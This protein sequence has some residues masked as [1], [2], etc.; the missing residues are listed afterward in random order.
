V[1][2]RP[3]VL[4][5]LFLVACRTEDT[6]VTPDPHLERMLVQEKRLAYQADPLPRGMAMQNPPDGTLPVDTPVGDPLVSEGVA[7]GQ[8]AERIPVPLDRAMLEQG[9]RRFNT[10]CATC[11]GELGD[12]RSVVADKMAL[13]RPPDLGTS[14]VRAYPPGRVFQTIRQGYGLMPSYRIEL[15]VRDTWSVVAYLH[16]L[17]LARGAVV[18][19]LPA[20]VRA[21]LAREAP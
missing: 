20:D 21:E 8:W 13:R 14:A 19:D 9:R 15:T 10:F 16:A 3:Y 7:N 2:G 18:A 5:S 6:V 17:D 12:G 4:V 11:H 1:K